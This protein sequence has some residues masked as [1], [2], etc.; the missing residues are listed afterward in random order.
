MLR[1]TIPGLDDNFWVGDDK[2]LA[3]VSLVGAGQG[4][5]AEGCLLGGWA[6]GVECR[7]GLLWAAVGGRRDAGGA[8][9]VHTKRAAVEAALQRQTP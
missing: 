5:A 6:V 7:L 2:S 9:Q 4:W 8:A 3:W 1:M